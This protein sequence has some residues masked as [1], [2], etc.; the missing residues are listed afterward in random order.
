MAIFFTFNSFKV[1]F[2]IRIKSSNCSITVNENK[3]II[4]YIDAV[5]IDN[6]IVV[7]TKNK[8]NS[9]K[10]D[11]LLVDTGDEKL[12]ERLRGYIEVIIGYEER[13]IYPVAD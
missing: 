6:I 11:P 8:L 4:T 2:C 3:S 1:L 12:N 13:A 5:G 9:F 10:L 7:A